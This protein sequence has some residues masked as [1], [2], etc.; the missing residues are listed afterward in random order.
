MGLDFGP[1]CETEDLVFKLPD[2]SFPCGLFGCS[3]CNFFGCPPNSQDN[4]NGVLGFQGYCLVEGGCDPCP[5]EICSGPA[6]ES[7]NRS[8]C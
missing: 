2:L 3:P 5:P 1:G 6:C 8:R 4:E 7:Y